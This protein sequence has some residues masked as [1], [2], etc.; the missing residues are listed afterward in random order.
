MERTRALWQRVCDG[1]VTATPQNLKALQSAIDHFVESGRKYAGLPEPAS[2]LALQRLATG[3]AWKIAAQDR[4]DR[5][6]IVSI[7]TAIGRPAH[8]GFYPKMSAGEAM[9]IR[10]KYCLAYRAMKQGTEMQSKERAEEAERFATKML[11]ANPAPAPSPVPAPVPAPAPA[12]VPNSTA[13]P[14]SGARA[15][16]LVEQ[17][18]ILLPIL[19]QFPD[20][21]QRTLVNALILGGENAGR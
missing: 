7:A 2:G 15:K 12:P 19:D 18:R 17:L 20:G 4:L 5:S 8:I 3:I 16:T 1:E 10:N 21:T 11:K 9:D 6:R 14:G 13:A